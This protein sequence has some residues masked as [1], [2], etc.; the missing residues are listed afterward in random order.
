[1][2]AIN[3]AGANPRCAITQSTLSLTGPATAYPGDTVTLNGTL[4]LSGGAPVDGLPIEITRSVDGGTPIALPD[5][6][7]AA[8][9]S[10]SLQ[11]APGAGTAV[12]RATFAGATNVSA[13]SATVTTVLAKEKSALS[14]SLS[15]SK[16]TYRGPRDTSPPI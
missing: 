10:F 14:L 3:D 7:A 2:K 13:E 11:D 12:Y 4:A 16:L 8:D 5:A 1:M 6:T 15:K 9:G